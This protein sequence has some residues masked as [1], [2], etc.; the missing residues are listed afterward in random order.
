MHHLNIEI[1]ARNNNHDGVRNILE[2]HQ[3]IFHGID[4]QIDTYFV[5]PNG[6]LKLREGSIEN[7]LIHYDRDNQAW[8]KASHVTL[9]TST[10]GSTLKEIL[11]KSCW[12]LA[13]VDKQRSIY[14]I[15]NIKFHLDVVAGL[16]TF[17]E[18]EAIDSDGTLWQEALLA[19]CQHYMD[20]FGI[21]E[22]DLLAMSYSDMVLG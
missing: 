13:V 15:D 4:H 10:P 11:T 9:Y 7:Y 21:Q 1:K 18:I 3:A 20:L 14:F 16:G 22:N 8:P 6:R 17:I 12:V 19:Q 5:V 2:E